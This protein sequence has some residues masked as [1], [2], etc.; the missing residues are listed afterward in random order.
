MYLKVGID[1]AQEL[2]DPTGSGGDFQGPQGVSRLPGVPGQKA[3]DGVLHKPPFVQGFQ[4]DDGL[5]VHSLRNLV[6][7]LNRKAICLC[8]SYVQA[9]A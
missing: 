5:G 1:G 2:L 4:V 3:S 6:A 9:G 8:N 7:K